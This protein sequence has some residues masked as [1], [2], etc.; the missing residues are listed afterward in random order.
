MPGF[1][2]CEDAFLLSLTPKRANPAALQGLG[3]HRGSELHTDRGWSTHGSP[4]ILLFETL[5]NQQ[6][7][8]KYKEQTQNEKKKPLQLIGEHQPE[9]GLEPR[10]TLQVR[11][12]NETKPVHIRV[13]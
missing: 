6:V 8:K 10:I 7:L 13:T 2:Q 9:P 5:P 3:S 4:Q 11:P 12:W 1:L